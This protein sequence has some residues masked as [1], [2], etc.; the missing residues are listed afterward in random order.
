MGC[1]IHIQIEKRV[2]GKWERVPWVDPFKRKYPETYGVLDGALEMPEAFENRN[3]D[4]FG[5]LADVR[6]GTW[7]EEQPPIAQPRG[8]PDDMAERQ[9]CDGEPEWLGDHSFSWVSLRELQ[10]YPWDEPVKKRGWT[11]RADVRN[12][13][14][15]ILPL[16]ASIGAPDDVRLVFGFDN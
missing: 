12:W 10:D 15:V 3:Y 14:D 16:L 5:V 9:L 2:D 4:L 7:G 8:W 1:D 11:R 6:N 13:P